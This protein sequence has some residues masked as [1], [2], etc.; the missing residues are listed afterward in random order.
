MAQTRPQDTL[1]SLCEVFPSFAES[2]ADEEAPPEDGLVDGVWY[3]WTHHRV[4]AEFLD[5]FS[6]NHSQFTEKQLKWLGEWLNDA[7]SVDGDLENA[8]ST[9]FLEH[10]PQVKINRVLAPYLSRVAK[11]KSHA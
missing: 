7:V 6:I 2:W 1:R 9:C 10:I 11:A 5:Y 8:V 3:E 4:M